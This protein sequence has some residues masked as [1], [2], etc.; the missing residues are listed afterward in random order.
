MR[1]FA[2]RADVGRVGVR[3]PF[4]GAL[5]LNTSDRRFV[6]PPNC[7]NCAALRSHPFETSTAN[8]GSFTDSG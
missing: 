5:P 7:S 2:D 3:R 6:D 1:V 4:R 8:E